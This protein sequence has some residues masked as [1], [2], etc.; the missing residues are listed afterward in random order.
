MFLPLGYLLAFHRFQ[1]VSPFLPLLRLLSP[2]VWTFG[3]ISRLYLGGFLLFLIGSSEMSLVMVY[4]SVFCVLF[5][6]CPSLL[7]VWFRLP[8][9]ADLYRIHFQ[10][11]FCFNFSLGICMGGYYYFSFGGVFLMSWSYPLRP[12][13]NE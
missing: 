7:C 3:Q 6:L 10:I 12:L 2:T 1:F 5:Y 9:F 4:L 13:L 11:C 8:L